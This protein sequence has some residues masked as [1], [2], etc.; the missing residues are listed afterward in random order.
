MTTSRSLLALPNELLALI[1]END[2]LTVEDLANLRL[3]CKHTKHFASSNLGE[4]IFTDLHIYPNRDGFNWLF[5]FLLSDFGTHVRSVR[6]TSW[7][8]Y[9]DPLEHYEDREVGTELEFCHLQ[10]ITFKYLEAPTHL[11][12]KVLCRATHLKTLTLVNGDGPCYW[13][14]VFSHTFGKIDKLLSSV[15][16]ECLNRLV[17]GTIHVSA[18]TLRQ[19]LDVHKDTISSLNI[20]SC[21]LV[22]GDWFE[23]LNWIKLNL[24]HLETLY[25]KVCQEA[26]KKVPAPEQHNRRPSDFLSYLESSPYALKTCS[27]RLELDLEGQKEIS[28]GLS[29]LLNA[30]EKHQ[31]Q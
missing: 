24:S 22:D 25:I 15:N 26:S 17:L 6:L 3:V 18:G 11:W 5:S 23:I 7:S 1:I 19:F 8:L 10:D 28:D 29:E 21:I 4:R 12:K 2:D 20:V 27:S 14:A 16:S 9:S 31:A 13:A 30:Q